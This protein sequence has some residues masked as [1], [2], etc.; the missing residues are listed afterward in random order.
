MVQPC[1]AHLGCRAGCVRDKRRRACQDYNGR[2]QWV[3]TSHRDGWCASGHVDRLQR[4]VH[5]LH[6]VP[7][8]TTRTCQWF[9]VWF[10]AWFRAL[11]QCLCQCFI[12]CLCSVRRFLASVQCLI[13]WYVAL[14]SVFTCL[15]RLPLL[16]SSIIMPHCQREKEGVYVWIDGTPCGQ[17][18]PHYHAFQPGE[19]NDWHGNNSGFV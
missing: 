19:P 8:N 14:A 11:D 3:Y 9:V 17:D 12:Q 2:S 1:I 4:Q 7:L 10:R 15:L 13:V 18:G 5:V 16:L 6:H